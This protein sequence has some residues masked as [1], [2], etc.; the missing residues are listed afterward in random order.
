M[1]SRSLPLLRPLILAVA[2][3]FAAMACVAA[4]AARGPA[5]DP[6]PRPIA[7][8]SDEGSDVAPSRHPR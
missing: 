7:D 5:P 8:V 3:P 6:A 1:P 2:L 4:L